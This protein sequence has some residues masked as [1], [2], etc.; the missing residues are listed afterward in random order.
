[1]SQVARDRRE[2]ERVKGSIA[3]TYS[4]IS[5]SELQVPEGSSEGTTA[6]LNPRGVLLTGA[7]PTLDLIVPLLTQKV[8]VSLEM[9]L[10]G[11]DERVRALA[12]VRW[13]EEVVESENRCSMG[14]AFTDITHQDRQRLFEFIVRQKS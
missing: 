6:D 10:P 9:N 4:L 13:I 11:S 7:L 14:L 12:N 2:F 3:V 8:L 5:V 1:M